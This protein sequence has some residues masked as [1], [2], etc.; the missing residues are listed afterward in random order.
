[1]KSLRL[2]AVC[3]GMFGLS[4]TA[5]A[6]AIAQGLVSLNYGE[7]LKADAPV[8]TGDVLSLRGKGKGKVLSAGENRTKKGRLY[9]TAGIYQ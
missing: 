1:M 9:V 8:R 5:A 4:R 3:A 7:C 6:E 2:D